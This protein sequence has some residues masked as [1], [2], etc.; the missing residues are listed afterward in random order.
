MKNIHKKNQ[1][2]SNLFREELSKIKNIILYW[3]TNSND[4]TSIVSFN[5]KGVNS[6]ELVDKLE[7]QNIILAV[8]EISDTKIVRASPHFFNTESEILQVIDAIK[9]L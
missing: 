6:Q 8:R 3:P 4:R 7:K 9:K 1:Y 5:I 2:L